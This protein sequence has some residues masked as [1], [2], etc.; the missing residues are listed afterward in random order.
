M[1][2]L[3]PDFGGRSLETVFPSIGAA[4]GVDGYANTLDLPSAPRYVV[5]LVDGMG[6]DLLRDHAM[7]AP[8]LSSLPLGDPM[9]VGVPSTT[10][11]SLTSLG[12]GLNA[13]RHGVLGYTNRIPGTN[14][15]LNSLKWDQPVDPLEWQP[16]ETVLQ[17]LQADD[18]A[19]TVVNDAMFAESGLTLCSQRGVPFR[20]IETVWE[21][22]DEIVDAS[23]LSAQS[24]VY[25][26]ESRLDHAGH[27]RGC[28]SPEWEA[29]L[30]TIDTDLRLLREDLPA[31]AVLV[32]TADHGMVDVPK[33]GRFDLDQHP[34]LRK[35]VTLVAG[36]ARFRH[37]HTRDGAAEDVALRWQQ[38]LGDRAV[39]RT[40]DGVEEW[41]GPIDPL[42]RPRIGDVLVASLGNFAVFSSVDF[43]IE[44]RMTG[45]HGSVTPTEM[46]VPLLVS[47]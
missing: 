25:A 22:L 19:V 5:M 20:G 2:T 42:V 3:L 10:A 32:V 21:R 29:M 44:Q 11:T 46:R 24:I 26:Y 35:D 45:F 31:D 18:I 23:E 8:F 39:V 28:G 41:F 9:T 47:R 13:G 4:I 16:H 15:R 17:R 14:Q 34:E 1:S 38:M 43:A 6:F 37:I 7:A 36:E 33:E 30:T 27:A 40:Q 12:T